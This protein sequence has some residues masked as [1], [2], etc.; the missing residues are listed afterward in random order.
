M[1]IDILNKVFIFLLILASLNVIRHGFFLIK[2]YKEDERFVLNNGELFIL[3]ISI[4][5]ILL[6]IIT[7]IKI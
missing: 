2:K 3:G 7:G 6:A 5:Y 1:L 4:S